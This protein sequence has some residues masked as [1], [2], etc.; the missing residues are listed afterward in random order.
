MAKQ[1][2][3]EAGKWTVC[4]SCNVIEKKTEEADSEISFETVKSDSDEP[5]EKDEEIKLE[6]LK[7]S[8]A[9]KSSSGACELK[10]GVLEDAPLDTQ[11]V[12]FEL[13]DIP[14]DEEEMA[15]ACSDRGGG[16]NKRTSTA[17]AV[18]EAEGSVC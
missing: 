11:D 17:W 18:R 3:Y 5:H 7:T 9:K 14:L 10:V 13:E 6:V 4:D 16:D 15:S 2:V 8:V 12:S 1:L